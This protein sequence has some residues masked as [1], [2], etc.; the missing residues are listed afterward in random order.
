MLLF[1]SSSLQLR[2]IFFP[3]IFSVFVKLNFLNSRGFSS[4]S[5]KA[6]AAGIS[7]AIKEGNFNLLDSSVY[8]S[9]LQRNETNL[10]LL[11]LESEPNSALKY[12]RWAEIS[13]KDP[14]FYT[15]A[16]VLIRN[17]MFD[18]AD[19]VFDE[20]ITNRG[21]DFNVLGSIRDRSLDAD[22]CKFLMECCCR[23]GMVDKALEIFVYSTQL[24]VV[25]PQD[26]VYRMLNSLIGS[27]R[28]DLI[29]DHFDKLC[30]GGI[31]PSG[32]SAHGFVLDA[33]FCKG[34]VTKALDFH[35]LVMERGF[36]V[37]IVSCNKVLKGL[38]VDQIEVAS[39]LLSLVLDCGPAPNVVTF[40]TLINGFCKRGEMDRA[41]DLFKVMEQRGI[42]PDLIAYSTLIDGYFKAGML[43]MGHKLF[44]QALHKGVKLDVVVFS[45]TIDVYVK[46]GD[47]ATASVV[48]KRM[49]C[50][51]ISPNVVTYT[52]LIKGLCQD[53]RIY[54]A[55]GM[56]GQ[57]LKRGMEPS[58]VTYSSL[59]DGFC[60]CGNLRSGFALYEDM[61]K[62]GYPP[63]VVIYGVLVDGL[64]KQGLMLHAMRFSVK[65]LGQSIRLNVVVFNSLI[66]GWCRLNR[67]DEALKVFRLMGIYGIKPDVAT[68]TTVMRVSI[69]EDAFCKHMK[70]TIGLQL[71]DLMQRNKISADIAVCNVV[72]HLLFKCHRIEDASK[73]FNN[74][75]EGKM[76]PDIVTYNTM[77][78]GYCS[79]RRLDEAERIFELLKVTPF[80][81]NTVTLTILIHV[82]CKNNDMDGAIR[83]FSI[84]AEKGS[85][86][87]AVTY[88]CLMDWF[89]KSVDIEG[90]FKLFEEMQEKGISP[91]IV[92]YSIIIDGL[93]K[94]GRVDEAT[95]IFHQAID[96]KLLPDVV[97]YAILIRGYCKVGRLVE[98]ALL[99]EHMLRNGVKPD[100]LLQ[101]ALS[102]YNPPKWLMSKG[103]WVH[104]KPMPD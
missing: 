54:E 42:E 83:M 66:D 102:E 3:R 25:I 67:F 70:P 94:R 100:D 77:I 99:Y 5:A 98:A 85:K 28:V 35:R 46:S 23:Y 30:R 90:S 101:R 38:S 19:K 51:G 69:M 71:F 104:D 88:G 91:S 80:G 50:Q 44:S 87:N 89:S 12:F 62:M 18:V 2:E 74:L 10:V 13:G 81:P 24:G 75:I 68:F 49:L 20:M 11:S 37:G 47:L 1:S 56:Y 63:D 15:I 79:L 9:N 17:G 65:M 40:C 14:S 8:G 92:S 39:R 41:F 52:I 95:N 4:D 31:E 27:D 78:C 36:R 86:P 53:G 84:M 97:A 6:L 29:A 22:V 58:I 96:A 103:V 21:K 32:V 43:G 57:I 93:C 73:F 82:L 72:I 61:I 26:S 33:L 48:Y 7:K 60:K 64:S 16:H 59:I 45:S 55:F 76:E 34:E